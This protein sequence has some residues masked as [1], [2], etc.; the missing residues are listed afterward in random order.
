MQC[1]VCKISMEKQEHPP[2][3]P[4]LW[5]CPQCGRLHTLDYK[6][7]LVLSDPK[8]EPAGVESPATHTAA[9][10][11][12]GPVNPETLE[13][14]AQIA[15]KS[16]KQETLRIKR[17]AR[18]KSGKKRR[19]VASGSPTTTGLKNTLDDEDKKAVFARLV[20]GDKP[21]QVAAAIGC[22]VKLVYSY[23]KYY[24]SDIEDARGKNPEPA[25]PA[26]NRAA[27]LE[28]EKK[29]SYDFKERLV[30]I[31][32][33]RTSDFKG[34]CEKYGLTVD[35]LRGWIAR[36]P[37][38]RAVVRK[39]LAAVNSL[40]ARRAVILKRL[41]TLPG[42]APASADKLLSD[43]RGLLLSDLQDV[44]DK[45][46]A[47]KRK[48]DSVDQARDNLKKQNEAQRA[49]LSDIGSTLLIGGD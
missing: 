18:L 33:A 16:I 27:G 30:I 38:Y 9:I 24:K 8:S 48:I 1:L 23:G 13:K 21:K 11:N 46:K 42:L 34:V 45:R 25:G 10:L 7:I 19:D 37:Y 49:I 41:K 40:R 5:R 6:N 12:P 44:N 35:Q 39:G 2:G 20:K 22:E 28:L 36:E 32:E 4:P 14:A 15:E 29:D 3:T 43:Y 26:A 47:I 31:D 17:S